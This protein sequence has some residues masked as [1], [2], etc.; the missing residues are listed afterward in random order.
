M[1]LRIEDYALIGNTRTAA[2]VGKDGSIDWLCVPRFDSPACFAALLGDENNGRWLIAP[3]GEVSRVSRRYRDATLILETEFETER[4]VVAVVDFMPRP[5]HGQQTDVVRIIEG[6]RGVVPM[7]TELILRFDYGSIVPWVRRREYGLRAVAGP[8]AVRFQSP[9]ELQ[10]R[11]LRSIARF[12]VRAGQAIP[13]RFT[14]FPSH[15][16][17][18]AVGEADQDLD[19]C[20]AWWHDW[21]AQCTYG[22]EWRDEVVRSLI[23]LKALT[24]APTGGIVA[25]VTTSL[26]EALGGARNWDYRYCWIRDATLTLDALACSGFLAE[27]RAWRDWL[28]R[29]MAGTPSQAQIMYS[30][31]G[32]RR[33]PEYE[34]PWLNGYQCSRPVRVGNA[35]HTQLQ[36]DVYGEI[37][38][39]FHLDRV[40]RLTPSSEGWRVQ[41]VLLEGLESAWQ[42]PDH[43]LW[44][45][46][47][48]P[49]HFTHSK[50]MSWVA[51]DRTVKAVE[52][53]GLQGPV[54]RWRALRDTIHDDVCRNGFDPERNAFVQ[55]YGGK[56]LDAALLMIPLVGF[57]PADDV[58]VIGTVEAITRELVVDGLVKRYSPDSGVAGLAGDE[59]TFVACSFWLADVLC[60]M[61]R[62]AEARELFER[63]LAMR[64]DV[65]L[66]AE[67]YDP[68]AG[69]QL[70]NFPQAFSH[71]GL[72]T[73][74]HN[75]TSFRGPAERRA[76][77]WTPGS[78]G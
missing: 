56:S 58:R 75:L 73:T 10:N 30:V 20:E 70:G 36:L 57:L 48:P 53:H 31:T 19:E 35:A 45:M 59:G 61:G 54:E 40:H 7:R 17:G 62:R 72:I 14:W 8:D 21:A 65:G 74:A 39:S 37:M 13:F 52:D 2:L 55:Y 33:L 42:C 77:T 29:A 60:L 9:V 32:A 28:L 71:V 24:Y 23:V 67:E 50:V 43:G 49:R 63:L 44:E 27:A 11:E 64:N 12:E 78:G 15:H 16:D 4:G 6:R 68:R 5:R 66:L 47:G 18:P 34:L 76:Q 22:G 26:P 1:G 3:E 25:A 41:Q 46:R 38:D 69:R 51:A